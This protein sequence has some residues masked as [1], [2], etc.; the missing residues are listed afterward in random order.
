MNTLIPSPTIPAPT[1][2]PRPQVPSGYFVPFL[3]RRAFGVSNGAARPAHGHGSFYVHRP[4][5]LVDV[6]NSPAHGFLFNG[7]RRFEPDAQQQ[8][9]EHQE[10][11]SLG[12][13]DVQALL[14]YEDALGLLG[15]AEDA[16]RLNDI[17]EDSQGLDKGIEDT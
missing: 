3:P 7:Y 4:P 1:S 8:E 13:A 5:G 15:D 9:E 16:T 12:L 11:S 6:P 14:D 10:A 17:V 2:S